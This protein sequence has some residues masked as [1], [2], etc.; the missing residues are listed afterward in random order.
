MQQYS[1]YKNVFTIYM[2]GPQNQRP[3]F[4]KNHIIIQI[5]MQKFWDFEALYWPEIQCKY[6]KD[7]PKE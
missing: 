5:G 1:T 4:P 3:K 6:H 2:S 7:I